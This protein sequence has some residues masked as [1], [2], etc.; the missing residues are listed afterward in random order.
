MQVLFWSLGFGLWSFVPSVISVSSAAIHFFVGHSLHGHANRI[1]TAPRQYENSRPPWH[2]KFRFPP[3]ALSLSPRRTTA[4]ED[5][6]E[7]GRSSRPSPRSRDSPDFHSIDRLLVA[8]D[9]GQRVDASTVH[10]DLRN[11]ARYP[12]TRPAVRAR[13]RVLA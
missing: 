3:R 7:V 5:R 13:Y 6:A 9:I 2:T 11:H 4:P 1:T 10:A 12:T 8:T